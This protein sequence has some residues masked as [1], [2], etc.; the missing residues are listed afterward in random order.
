M[1]NAGFGDLVSEWWH[2]QDD[3]TWE[4]LGTNTYVKEGLNCAGWKKDDTGW[5]Y[6]T[7]KGTYFRD[8]TKNIDGTDY[9]FD[10]DGYCSQYAQDE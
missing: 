1:L 6:R 4:A 8:T 3:E 2:F 7:E 10:A 9:T 5:R